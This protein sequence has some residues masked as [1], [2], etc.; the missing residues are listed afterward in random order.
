MSDTMTETRILF[1][2]VGADGTG[3]ELWI[4]GGGDITRLTDINPG[5]ASSNPQVFGQTGKF[6]YFAADNGDGRDLYRLDTGTMAVIA[7]G[8]ANSG[9]SFVASATGG[10][11]LSMDDGVHGRELWFATSGGSVASTG[12]AVLDG[13]LNPSTGG[14][15]GNTV[16]FAGSDPTKGIELFVSNGGTPW[17]FSTAPGPA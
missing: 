10:I 8:P 14:T 6:V 3:K 12:D 11:Y 2:G 9:P 15:I 17:Y 16:L 5:S 13:S 7:V 1:T 4:T